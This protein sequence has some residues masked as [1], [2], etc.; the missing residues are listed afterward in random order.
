MRSLLIEAGHSDSS[1]ILQTWHSNKNTLNL[2]H[3]LKQV[4]G[5][6]Q[7]KNLL[8]TNLELEN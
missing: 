5:L 2:Y 1:I 6:R 4:E 3:N 7:K 8:K